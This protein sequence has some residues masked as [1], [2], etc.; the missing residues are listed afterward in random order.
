MAMIPWWVV[1]TLGLDRGGES[2]EEAGLDGA[3]LISLLD[4]Q[5]LQWS[6]SGGVV[7]DDPSPRWWYAEAFEAEMPPDASALG[8]RLEAFLRNP[9]VGDAGRAASIGGQLDNTRLSVAVVGDVRSPRTRSYLHCFGRML[10]LKAG[11]KF[12]D[13]ALNPVAVIYLPQN[14]HELPEHA[15]I[16][17]FLSEL[18]TMMHLPVA[19]RPFASVIFLQ[20]TNSTAANPFGY[21]T[22]NA[23]QVQDSVAQVLFHLMISGANYLDEEGRRQA[24]AYFSVGA[25]AIYYDWR[26][27]HRRLAL[28]ACD[29]LL[30]KFKSSESP[31]FVD[32][33]QANLAVASLKQ[34]V[35]VSQLFREFTRKEAAGGV[36][37]PSFSFDSRVWQAAMDRRLHTVSA[38]AFYT[39]RLLAFYFF[40]Y[41]RYL[42]FRL[43]EYSR[44]FLQMRLQAWDDYLERRREELWDGGEAALGLRSLMRETVV[45]VLRGEYGQARTIP[46]ALSVLGKMREACELRG[47]GSTL[48]N[49]DEFNRLEVFSVPEELRAFYD[50]SPPTLDFSR[51]QRLFDG[52][53]ERIKRHPLPLA[54]FLRAALISIMLAFLGERLLDFLSPNVVN[55]EWLLD[56][57]GLALLLL[58]AAPLGVAFWRYQVRTLNELRKRIREYVAAVLRHAQTK[59]KEAVELEMSRLS[60]QAREYCRELEEY[61]ER[62]RAGLTA[63]EAEQYTYRTTAFHCALTGDLA[64][65][66]RGRSVSI[67][68]NGS[69]ACRVTVGGEQL[70]F[71]ECN[72]E[73]LGLLLNRFLDAETGDDMRPAWELLA[74]P[75]AQ[76]ANPDVL[77]T[78]ADSALAYAERL[79][80]TEQQIQLDRW[81][82]SDDE[83][84]REE[85]LD[86][87]RRLAAPPLAF[88]SG[89]SQP[90]PA[91]SEW[92]YHAPARLSPIIG[93]GSDALR[94]SGDGSVLS[95]ASYQPF[96]FI[97]ASPYSGIEDVALV[98]VLGADPEAAEADRQAATPPRLFTAA[99]SR[100]QTSAD[101]TI[102]SAVD[103]RTFTARGSAEE[104]IRLR[105]Q[106]RLGDVEESYPEL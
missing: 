21:V 78:F 14:A 95:F 13:K 58:G 47:L 38:W 106:L 61:L 64:I 65:P 60:E 73:M 37:L 20:D 50:D 42:P 40:L 6:R 44:L 52:L 9:L 36:K 25:A 85:T 19:E 46:Q 48:V 57:P 1:T 43:S 87:L 4:H 79:Y 67:L 27:H 98:R 86:R 53:V 91:R 59:A 81:L 18:H 80:D 33:G 66:G 90:P 63:P 8:E 62:V 3:A 69:L 100:L 102:I 83:R 76:E 89:A 7:T 23:A 41:L 96:G 26:G 34:K 56:V 2:L 12:P 72:E 51:E 77:T 94:V 49:L 88:H 74:P 32:E 71:E 68:S 5:L 22:L 55:L 15:E 29:S 54:L 101:L 11:E 103:G 104:I 24:T 10:R 35:G 105:G 93:E 45:G 16:L 39:T 70:L 31:P 75:V 28:A 84:H 30:G 82:M 92:K 99:S 17:Q 97:G